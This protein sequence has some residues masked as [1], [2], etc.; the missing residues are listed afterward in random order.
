M[1]FPR[2]N[3]VAPAARVLETF[4]ISAAVLAQQLNQTVLQPSA[5]ERRIAGW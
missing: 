1:S 2:L 4:D 5:S 3:K